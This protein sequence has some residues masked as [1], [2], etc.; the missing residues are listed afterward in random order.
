MVPGLT[1]PFAEIEVVT[2]IERQEIESNCQLLDLENKLINQ[3]FEI[4][5]V[6]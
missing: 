5:I 3:A 1:A 6:S 4:S 2:R